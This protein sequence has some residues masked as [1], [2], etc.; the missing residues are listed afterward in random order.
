MDAAVDVHC[1]TRPQGL[2]LAK[3][4][5]EIKQCP[6]VTPSQNPRSSSSDTSC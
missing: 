2:T 4:S 5:T 3:T 6:L 1:N